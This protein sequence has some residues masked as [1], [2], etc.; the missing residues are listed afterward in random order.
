MVTLVFERRF[1]VS[2]ERLFALHENPA[3]LETLHAGIGAGFRLVSHEGH[4]RPG[5]RV[6]VRYRVALV[7]VTLA[8]E[9]VLYEPPRRFG[10]RMIRGPFRHFFHTHEFEPCEKGTLL[11]DRLE[12]E[13]PG[14]LG[15]SL[16][17]RLFVIPMTRRVFARRHAALERYLKEQGLI[18]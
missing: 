7:P 10:E 9:H 2:P 13:L 17:L 8:F 4:V 11:R 18:P 16:A 12:M 15:G 3:M 14:R 1:A 5:A 6:V